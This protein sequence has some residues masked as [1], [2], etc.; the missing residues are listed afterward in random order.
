METI[1][2][3]IFGITALLTICAIIACAIKAYKSI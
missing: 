2:N 1:V 3:L